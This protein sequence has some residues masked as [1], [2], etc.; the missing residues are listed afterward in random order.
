M[1]HLNCKVSSFSWTLVNLWCLDNS[2]RSQGSC[3]SWCLWQ[4]WVCLVFSLLTF[5][6]DGQLPLLPHQL[7]HWRQA[8]GQCQQ[9]PQGCFWWMPRTMMLPLHHTSSLHKY[10]HPCGHITCWTFSL[11]SNTVAYYLHVSS[12]KTDEK[13]ESPKISI[14][15]L[16][17]SRSSIIQGK[18][19]QNGVH[20]PD[21][22][23]I[24]TPQ[25]SV[26]MNI[27]YREFLLNTKWKI[28]NYSKI[29]WHDC[30]TLDA[31]S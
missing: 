27:V 13:C 3:W 30:M 1:P 23:Q 24:H 6:Q 28:L 4:P 9:G 15:T 18:V 14:T 20:P 17:R 2:I 16:S 5:L 25:I 31:S 7:H 22:I 10:N 26:R 11:S 29:L 21:L 8:Q 19:W 12:E